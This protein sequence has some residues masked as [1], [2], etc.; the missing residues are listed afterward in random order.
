[1]VTVR[2]LQFAE[3]EQA[4]RL[5]GQ[6][7]DECVAPTYP[8]QGVEEFHRF[9]N[10]EELMRQWQNGDLFFWGA[11]E[12]QN[13]V[14]MIAVRRP[15]HI[16]MLYV[17]P[18]YQ[19]KGVGRMLWQQACGFCTHEL[20]MVR[21]TVNAAPSAAVIYNRWG[22]HALAPEQMQ[23]G[24]RFIPME[25]IFAPANVKPKSNSSKIA[26]IVGGVILLIVI[27]IGILVFT[28]FRTVHKVVDT[29]KQT[30][31]QYGGDFNEDEIF[32][33]F[34]ED[35]KLI[36]EPQPEVSEIKDFS[37]YEEENLSYNVVEEKYQYHS[38]GK[39]EFDVVYPQLHNLK[40][41]KEKEV[42]QI[43][44]ECA[45]KSAEGM[46]LHPEANIKEIAEEEE[47]PYFAST[48]TYKV[49]YL[50]DELISVAFRDHYFMGSIY[51]ECAD[52]KTR[53]INLKTGECYE[54]EQIIGP[55][56]E[57]LD[58]MKEGMKEE[59]VPDM[60]MKVL[61]KDETLNQ[62]FAG[63]IVENR[64][65]VNFLLT[66]DGVEIGVNY[67]YGGD[68]GIARGWVTVPFSNEEIE[69]FQKNSEIWKLVESSN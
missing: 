57:F 48:V 45:M 55:S 52:L 62:M 64:Y 13:L 36:E 61:S 18:A 26:L 6:V 58:I 53:T 59:G 32:E 51:L 2:S 65:Y 68:D 67:H 34:Q 46:Y 39:F 37:V 33:K 5:A 4:L 49:T 1:M 9:N 14:G 56:Q 27:L 15:A 60:A 31:E 40:N 7:F 63:E 22:F 23:D 47:N 25:Y 42:N 38:E 29:T 28:I 10:A 24:I 30:I 20:S 44:K 41:G 11:Y 19:G 16:S 54:I 69:P 12:E 35:N 17:L 66:G 3:I 8:M 43:L 21:I 50:S